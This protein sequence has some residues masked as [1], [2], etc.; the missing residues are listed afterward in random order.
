MPRGQV[1]VDT[2]AI[3]G[4]FAPEDFLKDIA[5]DILQELI[6]S[7]NVQLYTTNWV[8]YESLSKL[9]KHGINYCNKY[10]Q[11][12][13]KS[14]MVVYKV[15]QKVKEKALYFF[16]NYKDKLWSVV[17]CISIAY[18][19]ENNIYYVFSHDSHFKQAGLIPLMST[20]ASG[21][22]KKAYKHLIFP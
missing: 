14:G 6:N 7:Y 17:D 2:S 18:M 13:E 4:L 19:Y 16:W 5:K 22:P 8:E 11:F 1:F 21:V 9:K 3:Y 12:V 15:D 10:K 20:D